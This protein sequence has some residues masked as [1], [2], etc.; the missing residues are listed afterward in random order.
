MIKTNNTNR[1]AN[2]KLS[3][4]ERENEF[5]EKIVAKTGA[6]AGTCSVSSPSPSSEPKSLTIF[7]FYSKAKQ[8]NH[9]LNLTKGHRNVEIL[10]ILHTK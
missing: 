3:L 2:H 6:S 7:L 4:K 1:R 8:R 10:P 9:T 5:I